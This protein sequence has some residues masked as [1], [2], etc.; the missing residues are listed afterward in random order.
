MW[1]ANRKAGR[2]YKRKSYIGVITYFRSKE[3]KPGSRLGSRDGW[4]KIAL[5]GFDLQIIL[6]RESGGLACGTVIQRIGVYEGRD[7]IDPRNPTRNEVRLVRHDL[8]KPS[9]DGLRETVP[10]EV[11]EAVDVGVSGIQRR[12]ILQPRCRPTTRK[13][14]R[15]NSRLR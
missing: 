13:R 3:G 8:R 6:V 5:G 7:S 4:R 15:V 10:G 9:P 11:R 1:A 12:S 14:T 2:A